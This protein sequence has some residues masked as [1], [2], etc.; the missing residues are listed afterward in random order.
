MFFARE[1]TTRMT[2]HS[3]SLM[4]SKNHTFFDFFAA[5][6]FHAFY[7]GNLINSGNNFGPAQH[8]GSE[9]TALGRTLSCG[10]GDSDDGNDAKLC[11]SASRIRL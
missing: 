2:R 1:I 6:S 10:R 9:I 4:L 11:G 5:S 8:F 3:L 7:C